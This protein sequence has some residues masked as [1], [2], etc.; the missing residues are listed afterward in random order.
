M[1]YK[2]LNAHLDGNWSNERPPVNPS[3][4]VGDIASKAQPNA[5]TLETVTSAIRGVME[6]KPDTARSDTDDDDDP[7][8]VLADNLRRMAISPSDFRFFGKSSGAILLRTAIGLKNEYA[9]KDRDSAYPEKP[10]TQREEFWTAKPVRHP[11]DILFTF[12]TY[13]FLVGAKTEC[14]RFNSLYLSRPGS[15]PPLYRSLFQMQ[16]P[17]S[18]TLASTDI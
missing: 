17:L 11:I 10:M 1:L 3:A 7:T 5:A 14:T 18:P 6:D 12:L 9:G 2:E 8:L 16:Q 13:V 15:R 4:L